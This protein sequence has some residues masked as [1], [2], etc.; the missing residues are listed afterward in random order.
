MTEHALYLEEIAV[1]QS[2][3]RLGA[4]IKV[5]EAKGGKAL[6]PSDR[7][8]LHPLVVPLVA[9]EAQ[10]DSVTCL[11]RWPQ[12]SQYKNMVMPVVTMTRGAK[13]MDLLSRSVDEH[14]HRLLAEEDMAGPGFRPLATAAGPDGM[15]VYKSGDAEASGF[16]AKPQMYLI[17]KVGFFPDVCESL[18]TGHLAR[19]DQTSAL[20]ASE[21]YMRNGYFPGWA[22]PYEFAAELLMG[23]KREEE[24]RD[25]AR[26]A[27]RLPWWTLKGTYEWARDVGQL[28][29]TP[30]EVR[31]SLSEEAAAAAQAQVTKVKFREPRSK[32]QIAL[33]NAGKLMD[34]VVAGSL[35][36]YD[37]IRAD[38]AAAYKEAGLTDV[39]NF[40]TSAT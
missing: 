5:L 9:D 28:K 17:K 24:A 10:P 1:S 19:N 39:S 33:D 2:P 15:A 34:M 31:Y 20:V 4:L 26:V 35:P 36:S 22:R 11:L 38:L 7:A 12:P 8:G 40:I 27:L 14:L 25:M 30:E 16:G 23:M 6:A 18:S 3:K 32:Q 37:S 21:W 29:G 13:G